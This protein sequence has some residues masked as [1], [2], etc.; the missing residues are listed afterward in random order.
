MRTLI[1]G[2]NIVSVP[3]HDALLV[4]M[5]N[6]NIEQDL[7]TTCDEESNKHVRGFEYNM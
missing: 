3:R 2:N 7:N 4:E 1:D 6:E 5:V